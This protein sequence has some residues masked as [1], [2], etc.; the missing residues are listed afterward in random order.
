MSFPFLFF[1][2]KLGFGC[3]PRGKGRGGRGRLGGSWVCGAFLDDDPLFLS[4]TRSLRS[5]LGF[6]AISSSSLELVLTRAITSI[7]EWAA[8]S[9]SNSASES[10]SSIGLSGPPSSKKKKNGLS[11][12]QGRSA[13]RQFPPSEWLVLRENV[14]EVV[15]LVEGLFGPRN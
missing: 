3:K 8:K 13:K 12:P 4:A 15:Q 11:Q 9:L 10:E 6:K 5:L 2:C 7:R 1:F 14:R